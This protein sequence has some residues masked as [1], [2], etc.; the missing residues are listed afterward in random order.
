MTIN[1]VK[2]LEQENAKLKA[3][4]KKYAAIN[5]QETK[6][7]AE[8][9]AEND[10][11]K[12]KNEK[13]NKITGIFSARLYEK[14]CTTLQEIKA[15]ADAPSPFVDN[16]KIKSATEVGYDYAAICNELESRLHEVLVLITKAEEEW[17]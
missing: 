9:K 7:Y 16:F 6:N 5:E 13:L 2:R 17:I 10:R 4:I 11:L 15:I 12:E 3:K 14:Y 1:D 8:L